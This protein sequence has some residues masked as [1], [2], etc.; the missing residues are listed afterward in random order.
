MK[1]NKRQRRA[2]RHSRVRAKIKG[3]AS[4]PRVSIFRS[5]RHIFAQLIDDSTGKVMASASDLKMVK[6]EGK[7]T[8]GSKTERASL[9]GAA[10]A[11]EA[12]KIGISRVA[13]DRGGYKYH[14]Q[15]KALAEGLRKGGLKF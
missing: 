7:T 12:L 2:R 9:V 3:T 5:N 4:I 10:L 13:F 14:G 1:V 15:V 8:K 6:T 11:A